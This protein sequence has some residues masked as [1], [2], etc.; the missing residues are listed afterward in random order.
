[1]K[2]FLT[3][4]IDLWQAHWIGVLT[5]AG[6]VALGWLV[7]LWRARS[8]WR[9][10]E[11]FDRLNVS[12]NILSDNR[13][14]IRTLMEKSCDQVF[15]NAQLCRNVLKAAKK[16]TPEDSLLP[17][18][19]EDYWYYLNPVLND[20]SEQYSVG[21]LRRDAGE[22]VKSVN[23]LVCLT[24]ESAGTL[25]QRKI[26]AMLIQK[27][28]LISLATD[29]PPEFESATHSTRWKT[30]KQLAKEYKREP[31]RFLELEICL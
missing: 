15:L 29:T 4:L 14:Q 21:Y 6:L 9:R 25:R 23:Y 8:R 17:L 27:N 7:G 5:S 3:S 1:M 24:C 16:T 13:L 11:F 2:E 28:T 26:R 10:K 30:L 18:S 19:L 20:V 12:L 31:K 22:Q